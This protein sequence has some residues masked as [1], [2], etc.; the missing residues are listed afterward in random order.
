MF[1]RPFQVCRQWPRAALLCWWVVLTHPGIF[2]KGHFCLDGLLYNG[3]DHSSVPCSC[4]NVFHIKSSNAKRFRF[5]TPVGLCY[6]SP[7]AR[8]QHWIVRVIEGRKLFVGVFFVLFFFNTLP[9]ASARPLF[10]KRTPSLICA[11]FAYGFQKLKDLQAV[12]FQ[13]KWWEQSLSFNSNVSGS[14]FRPF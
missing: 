1:V 2:L 14:F 3:G 5:S 10:Q 4:I 6:F 8:G 13:R 12:S 11:Y 7:V 9:L